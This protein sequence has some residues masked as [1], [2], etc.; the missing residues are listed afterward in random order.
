VTILGKVIWFDAPRGYGF[1]ASD[2]DGEEFFCHW[3]AIQSEG[4]KQLKK[5]QKV[6]F[7]VIDGPKGKPQADNVCV[8]K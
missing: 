2:E 4:Y 7:S 3:S 6:S 5:D 1:L 8:V